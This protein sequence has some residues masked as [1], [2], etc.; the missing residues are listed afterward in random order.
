MET[1]RPTYKRHEATG[2]VFPRDG[3]EW[4]EFEGACSYQPRC[5]DILLM[6]YPKSGTTWVQYM[7]YLLVHDMKPVPLGSRLDSFAPFLEKG[8]LDLI[9]ALEKSP[10]PI[11]THLSFDVMPWRAEPRYVCVVRNPKDVCVSLYHH[12]RGFEKYYH[13][14]DGSFD[15]F[16]EAFLEGQVD[17]ADY[18]DHLLSLWHHRSKENVL[19]LTYEDLME[20]TLQEVGR[21][22]E[23]VRPCFPADWKAPDLGSLVAAASFDVMKAQRPEQ[24]ASTRPENMPGFIRRGRVGDWRNYLTEDQNERLQSKFA[25]KLAGSGA[26]FLWPK[27]MKGRESA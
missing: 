26:E 3:F 9:G 20:R 18:H 22:V 12:V 4:S 5:D 2:W 23:H 24:W 25:R 10:R 15:D 14:T 8:G 11:K 27:E 13:F 17:S 21:L 19:L 1:R 6:T 7:L 16:F